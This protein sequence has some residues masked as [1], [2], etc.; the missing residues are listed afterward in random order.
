M[1]LSRP[2]RCLVSGVIGAG[3][4]TMI[5]ETMRRRHPDAPRMDLLGMRALRQLFRSA[6]WR[7]PPAPEVRQLALA[8]DIVANS[9]YYAAISAPTAAETWLRAVALGSAA[10]V[11]AL[12]LPGPL[13]LGEPPK[14]DRT[15]NQVMTIG[16]YLAG[17]LAAAGAANALRPAR[18]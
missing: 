1:T 8:G 4:L 11:G 13:G 3:A 12:M 17:A 10:G 15:A 5:H 16:W 9:V 14:S 6:G 2:L 7:V 18:R